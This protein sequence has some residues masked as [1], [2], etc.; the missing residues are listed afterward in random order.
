MTIYYKIM[1]FVSIPLV[2]WLVMRRYFPQTQWTNNN[3]VQRI[4]T[5]T[6]TKQKMI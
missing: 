6:I 3:K 4:I 2:Q 1:I 5:V